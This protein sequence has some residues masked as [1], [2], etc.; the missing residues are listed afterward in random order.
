MGDAA[1]WWLTCEQFADLAGLPTRTAR[2]AIAKAAAGQPVRKW[3]VAVR[4]TESRGGRSGLRYE[5]ALSSLPEALQ[6]AFRA[7]HANANLA[8]ACDGN[9]FRRITPIV[10]APNQSAEVL[11]RWRIIEDA[12]AYPSR[13]SERAAE[14][15]RASAKHRVPVRTIQRWLKRLD[16]AGDDIAALGRALPSDAGRPRIVVSREFDK[17]FLAAGH[18]AEL[19]AELGEFVTQKLRAWWASPAQRHGWT[20]VRLEVVTELRRECQARG[21]DLVRAAFHLSRYRVQEHEHFRRVD[22]YQHDRKRFDDEKPR[23]TRNNAALRPMQL[24]CGDVQPNDCIVRRPDGTGEF[25]VKLIAFQDVGTHRIFPYFVQVA[26]GEGVRQEHIAEAF[27]AM[28]ADPHWGMPEGL[29][30]DNGSE[31]KILAK[32][33]IKAALKAMGEAGER[34]VIHAKPYSGASKPIESK[35]SML[36][37][38][39]WS[40]MEGFSGGDRLNKKTHQVGRKTKPYSGTFQDF[41]AEAT[42]RIRDFEAWPLQSGSFKGKSPLDAYSEHLSAGWRPVRVDQLAL[43][44]TFCQASSALVRQGRVRTGGAVYTHPELPTLNGRTVP[45]S[46]PWRRGALPLFKH[47]DHGWTGLMPA[48]AHLPLDV[49]GAHEA[50]RLQ[51]REA[52][53]IR[54]LKRAAGPVDPGANVNFRVTEIPTIAAPAPLMDAMLAS[55]AEDMAIARA[56]A[57]RRTAEQQ[58]ARRKPRDLLAETIQLEKDYG[59]KRA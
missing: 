28:V 14:I 40:Q 37:R 57:A 44:A 33:E 36:Q 38:A 21:I 29:Y 48:M 5:V 11:R 54:D 39:V 8:V 22:I 18:S 17:R 26:K 49:A 16:D 55:E 45:L 56:D 24:V 7:E 20:R 31:F 3:P 2:H 58:P 1:A 32:T 13:S 27:C 30:L 35:F 15:E 41:V 25:T 34:C 46:L 19:L 6:R 47:P 4:L 53:S 23:I 59:L 51:K 52:R 50:G 9:D 42:L 43:D 10:P 12:A